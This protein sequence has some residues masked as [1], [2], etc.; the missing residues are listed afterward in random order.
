MT[1][2]CNP[3]AQDRHRIYLSPYL[4]S[5]QPKLTPSLVL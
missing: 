5:S 1:Y 3:Q 2:P 4:P